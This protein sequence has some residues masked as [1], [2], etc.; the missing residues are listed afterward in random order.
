MQKLP[1]HL[2]QH[3]IRFWPATNTL[4]KK[5]ASGY[6][7]RDI[8]VV[9]SFFDLGR[10]DWK[11]AG[12][13]N[14]PFQRSLEHYFQYFSHLAKLKNP[15]VIFVAPEHAQRVLDLRKAAGL[16]GITSVFTISELFEIDEVKA[17]VAEVQ[18]KMTPAFQSWVRF[19]KA[20]EFTQP[21]YAVLDALKSIFVNTAIAAKAVPTEQVAWLDF[22]YARDENCFDAAKSWRFDAGRKINLFHMRPMDDMPNFKVV[23]R[24][25]VYFQGGCKIG[26]V[27]AWP[28]F[29]EAIDHALAGLL[30]SDLVDDEQTLLLIAWRAN[31]ERY[32]IHAMDRRDWRVAIRFFNESMTGGDVQFRDYRFVNAL[33]EGGPGK[34]LRALAAAAG[35]VTDKFS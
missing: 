2:V 26:P 10:G 28:A 7:G 4:N 12:G 32:R 17:L 14:S 16:E 3:A 11:V 13:K 23:Q 34:V 6:D 33:K 24:G 30:T 22:G 29:S 19:P 8:T 21:R 1:P 18:S 5:V 27:G 9:T 25:Y 35:R 20:P 15:M 31:P